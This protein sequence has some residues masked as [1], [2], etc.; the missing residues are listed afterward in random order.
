MHDPHVVG[1]VARRANVNESDAKSVLE[2]LHGLVKEGSVRH[3]AIHPSGTHSSAHPEDPKLV[4]ELIERAKSH[5]LGT[6]FLAEGSLDSVAAG[7]QTHA[8]T[9]EAA[10]ERLRAQDSGK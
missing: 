2:A 3:D 6:E 8:F 9:V 1:K 4:E 5:P 10:R 7:F